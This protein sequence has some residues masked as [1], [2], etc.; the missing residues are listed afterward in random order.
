MIKSY[1]PKAS[2]NLLQMTVND[3]QLYNLSFPPLFI[4][5]AE[6]KFAIYVIIDK[7]NIDYWYD[8]YVM[9]CM[10]VLKMK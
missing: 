3:S 1:V 9:S 4:P 10:Y 2:E 7:N 5:S 8:I 6:N